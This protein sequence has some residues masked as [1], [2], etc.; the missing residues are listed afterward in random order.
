MASAY[1]R[2]FMRALIGLVTLT[3]LLA[4]ASPAS[5]GWRAGLPLSQTTTGSM[6]LAMTPSGAATIAWVDRISTANGFDYALRV[7]T[8][9]P[10]GRWSEPVTLAR[11]S[12]VL[13]SVSVAVSRSGDVVLTWMRAT[14]P[15]PIPGFP[16][17]SGPFEIKA[18]VRPH[19]GT[20]SAPVTIS[21]ASL[22][23]HA[24]WLTAAAADGRAVVVWEQEPA[25]DQDYERTVHA[26]AYAAA[27]DWSAPETIS[28]PGGDWE[29]APHVGMDDNGNATVVWL[30]LTSTS[31]WSIGWAERPAGGPWRRSPAPLVSAEA[32]L[33]IGG[34]VAVG[35]GGQVI[36]AWQANGQVS[37]AARTSGWLPASLGASSDPDVGQPVVSV[38]GRGGV[39]VAWSTGDAVFAGRQAPGGSWTPAEP[40]TDEPLMRAYAPL[41]ATSASGAALVAWT[42]EPGGSET[43]RIDARVRAANGEWDW[44]N[45]LG[46]VNP[47][48]LDV[49]MDDDGNGLVAMSTGDFPRYTL[50]VHAYDAS[51]PDVTLSSAPETATVGSPTAFAA[52]AVDRWS[53]LGA[54]TWDFGDAGSAQGSKVSHVYSAPGTY[55]LT[56]TVTDSLGNA[57]T[58]RRTVAV[59]G[60][61]PSPTP[62]APGS[63]KPAT[64]PTP[65][66]EPSKTVKIHFRRAYST[67][68]VARAKA[69]RGT[70]E[71]TLKAGAH[72]LKRVSVKLDRRCRFATTFSLPRTRLRGAT[73]V[74][75][76]AHFKGNRYLGRATNVFRGIPVP[77]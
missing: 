46:V 28:E 11:D 49:A 43:R 38:D 27:S 29:D 36:A 41:I 63:G 66:A 58:L 45:T 24:G 42:A 17:A 14:T 20:W 51:G 3:A 72:V 23:P 69:C 39:T 60:V 15:P 73:K 37:A 53:P 26:V 48:A 16:F 32:S 52:D 25:D 22:V 12:L 9:G 77:R 34:S 47:Q 65:P 19:G 44:T 7:A 21:G 18:A 8:S 56:L 40:V 64:T 70:V 6:D 35:A 50:S 54:Y 74:T 55:P 67:P 61:E 68:G 33:G 1:R 30:N 57:T 59:K 71:L 76:V 4:L 62:A 10:E 13:G 5:A 31:V 2:T 75:V